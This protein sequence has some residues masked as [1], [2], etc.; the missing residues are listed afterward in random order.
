ML[1][2]AIVGAIATAALALPGGAAGAGPC[3]KYASASGSDADP[4]SQTQP[5]RSTQKLAD[6]LGAGEVGCLRAG[7]Y[8][9]AD[10]RQGGEPGAPITL[11]SYPGERAT[12][13][14]RFWVARTAPHVVVEG[15]YLNGR[16][17]TN[18]PSPTISASDVT[19]R[20]NDVTNDHTGI[21]FLLGSEDWGRADGAVIEKNRVHDCGRLPAKGF[22]HGIYVEAA[23]GARVEGNWFYD[24]ADFGV[25]LYPNADHTVV[26]GN[27]IDGNGKGLTIGGDAGQA[28]DDNRVEGNVISNSTRRFNVESWSPDGNPTPQGNVV[29]RNCL[30]AGNVDWYHNGG[31]DKEGTGGISMSGN[32]TVSDTG[33][34]SSR[35]KDFRL[36]ADS[37]CRK[38]FA[39][40]PSAVAGPD[41][42]FGAMRPA[43]APVVT[44]QVS[45]P[46]VSAGTPVKVTGKVVRRRI[47]RGRR[48]DIIARYK[49][50]RRVIAR[51]R[52]RRG[53]RF[54]ARP[55]LRLRGGVV[56]LRAVVH[57]VGRSRSVPVRIRRAQ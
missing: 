8:D 32:E 29:N 2:A 5:F 7:S 57:S 41:N 36:S 35:A 33:F 52:I 54:A 30:K 38:L 11:R 43:V 20:N 22:D 10:L 53:G 27:V 18:H 1:T 46:A 28:S 25:H 26:R 19:F 45:A 16:N 56:R 12:V 55:R 23:T 4:G 49:G 6:S 39:G 24:N 21:C 50:R 31:V 3:S 13:T 51:T 44:L 47:R 14:G 9:G 34:E 42:A 48:V 17:E 37:P 40:D 15:L